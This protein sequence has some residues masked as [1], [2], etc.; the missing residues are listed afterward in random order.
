MLLVDPRDAGTTLGIDRV[1]V[2][3]AV[4]DLFSWFLT[5][6]APRSTGVEKYP[7]AG[8]AKRARSR[9]RTR[10]IDRVPARLVAQRLAAQGLSGEPAESPEAVVRRVF[11]VQAQDLRAARLAVRSRS[12]GLTSADLDEALTVRRSLVVT[13]LNRGTLH[14]VTAQDYP[15]L[16]ALTTPQLATANG[17][18]LWQEGVTPA[19][20]E[21]GVQVIAEAVREGPQSREAIRERLDRAGVPTRGQALVHVLFAASIA[22]H[23]VRGPIVDG[24]HAFVGPVAWLGAP[25]PLDREAALAVLAR[26]Y[27]AGHGPA[28]ARDLVKW[29]SVTLG[30]AR[31]GFAAIAPETEAAGGGLV[32]LAGAAPAARLPRPRLL[33][34]FDPILHGWASREELVGRLAEVVTS[35]GIFRPTALVEG[36]VVA[37]WGLAGGVITLRPLA[38]I[39]VRALAALRA[40][41][42]DV[43]RFLGLPGRDVVVE[44]AGR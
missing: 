31:R 11:A 14:L 33:G 22:G 40:E 32:S 18:R 44:T 4:V 28:N 9:R 38:P 25:P 24:H 21:L 13:W 19:Q 1:L 15:V 3:R 6:A 23:V 17:R 12:T 2:R 36:R 37:T 41:A 35:N 34:G 27:L 8:P 29:A 7:R 42:R 16:Q 20:A 5:H 43:L 30:D 26:R 10:T 39:P